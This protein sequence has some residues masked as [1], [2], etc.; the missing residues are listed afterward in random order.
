MRVSP[1]PEAPRLPGLRGGSRRTVCPLQPLP[2]RTDGRDGAGP[3][4]EVGD[5]GRTTEG[6]VDLAAPQS[7]SIRWTTKSP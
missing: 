5:G 3:T 4:R 2:R 6:D 7:T 1:A